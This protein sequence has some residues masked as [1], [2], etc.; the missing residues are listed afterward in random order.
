MEISGCLNQ[1]KV[2]MI[3]ALFAP[4]NFK[5]PE[6]L[7]SRLQAALMNIFIQ[8]LAQATAYNAKGMNP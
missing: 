1:I 7:V 2:L 4:L 5:A 3:P 6:N 8:T